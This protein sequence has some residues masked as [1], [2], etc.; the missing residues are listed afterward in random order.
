MHRQDPMGG[1]C[2]RG[3]KGHVMIFHFAHVVENNEYGCVRGILLFLG[4]DF[5]PKSWFLGCMYVCT[6]VGIWNGNVCVSL[7]PNYRH[8]R[9][10]GYE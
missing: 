4:L 7:T 9:H 2:R 10:E 3:Q 1:T 5:G 6:Y 8:E